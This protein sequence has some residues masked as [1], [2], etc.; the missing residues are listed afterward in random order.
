MAQYF[1]GLG[2]N[3]GNSGLTWALRK[4][5]LTGAEAI[6]LSAGDWVWV[7]P[8]TYPET[9]TTLAAGTAGNPITFAGDESGLFTDGIGGRVRITGSDNN[10]TITR[11][12][13]IS[14]V[15][16]YRTWTGFRTDSCSSQCVSLA[17][18]TNNIIEKFN[19]QEGSSNGI[20]VNGASQANN[21]IRKCRIR[22]G[23]GFGI[24]FTHTATVS[25]TNHVVENCI[26]TGYPASSVSIQNQRIGG[27]TLRNITQSGGAGLARVTTALAVGQIMTVNNCIAG[28]GNL[29]AVH[30]TVLGEL[31]ED[32]NNFFGN[33]A[34]RLNVAVGANSTAYPP[35][36]ASDLLTLGRTT[37][38]EW[39]LADFSPLSAIAG[40]GVPSDDIFG[41]AR[42]T[43]SSWGAIQYVAGQRP[44][45]A[46]ESRG[47]RG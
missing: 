16:N 18:V 17:N 24:N 26:V 27:I 32:Y 38:E 21:I 41:V 5:T 2:G 33:A 1:V 28:Q 47:R 12:S 4:A 14:S 23:R 43:P 15:H 10:T 20:L 8:G 25:N 39:A 19:I 30:A 6:G 34:D 37:F 11:A 45:D 29:N 13:G 9:H 35:G 44:I 31:I 36:F 46:G 3:N 40:T 22:V 7:G 42:V